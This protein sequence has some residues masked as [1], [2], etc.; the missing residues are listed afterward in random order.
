MTPLD[1]VAVVA[2][3]LVGAL[4]PFAA[5]PVLHRL[6]ALDVPNARSSHSYPTLRGGGVAPL[7]ALAVG[8]LVLM[9]DPAR[10]EC[11][12][13]VTIGVAAGMLGFIDDLTTLRVMVRLPVQLLLGC[14]AGVWVVM[15]FGASWW[16]LPIAAV[17][18]AGYI[19]V[20]NF[21]DGVDGMSAMHGLVVGGVFSWIG[22]SSG[23]SW[24][25]VGG[26]LVAAA[27]LAFLPWNVLGA[28]MFLGDVGSYLLGGVIAV[29][30]LLATAAGVPVVVVLA[31]LSVYLFDAALTLALRIVRRER[32]W[33][34][35]RGHLYQRLQRSGWSHLRVSTLVASLSLLAGGFAVVGYKSG[36]TWLPI[37]AIVLVPLAYMV[38]VSTRSG[39]RVGST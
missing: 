13:A 25:S 22:A 17:G 31:P 27:F 12:A 33:E 6:G 29:F 30:A 1:V 5:R 23:L 8:A 36:L 19:N 15:Y 2:A 26:L 28:R 39:V 24:L 16:I 7:L 38:F 20:A 4:L 14:A 32:F 9:A 3:L 18:V 34:A 11:V 37:L 10:V 35:H 21:M